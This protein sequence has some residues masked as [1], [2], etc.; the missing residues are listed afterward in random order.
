MVWRG[1]GILLLWHMSPSPQSF[2]RVRDTAGLWFEGITFGVFL[3]THAI[4]IFVNQRTGQKGTVESSLASFAALL[5]WPHVLVYG[6]LG[7]ASPYGV[8]VALVFALRGLRDVLLDVGWFGPF[9]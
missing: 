6:M 1:L 5:C 8:D 9:G 2:S 7:H 4:C 3:V